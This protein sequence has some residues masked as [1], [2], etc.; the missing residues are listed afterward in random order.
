[1]AI[2]YYIKTIDRFV[3]NALQLSDENITNMMTLI[4]HRFSTIYFEALGLA[5]ATDPFFNTVR[6]S[7]VVK[8]GENF[9]QLWKGS[10]NEQSEMAIA[11][12]LMGIEALCRSILTEFAAFVIR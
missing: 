8:F 5:L 1:M 4:H 3:V 12:M 7:I 11:G 9:A 10:T 2:K 6:Y